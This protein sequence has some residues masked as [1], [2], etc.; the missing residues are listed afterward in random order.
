M[1][2]LKQNNLILSKELRRKKKF[3]PHAKKKAKQNYLVGGK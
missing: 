2:V 1:T 3:P